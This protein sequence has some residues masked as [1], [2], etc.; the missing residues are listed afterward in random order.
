MTSISFT[1]LSTPSAP[2]ASD[3]TFRSLAVKPVAE[4]RY[5]VAS[6]FEDEL[7][8]ASERGLNALVAKWA[9]SPEAVERGE[10]EAAEWYRLQA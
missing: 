4:V 8:A 1:S 10:L 2:S 5:D 9:G 6:L 7:D 3:I